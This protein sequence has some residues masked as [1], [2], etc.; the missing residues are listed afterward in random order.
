VARI[1]ARALARGQLRRVE[2]RI[3][4]DDGALLN[5]EYALVP[6]DRI[7]V[8]RIDIEGNAT[9]LDRVIRSQF[10]TVEGDPFNPRENPRERSR[11]R[12]VGYFSDAEVEARAGSSPDQVVI[13]VNVEE[14]PTGSLSFGATT[15]ATTA[16]RSSSASRSRNFLGAGSGSSG[17]AD[18]H[19]QP[20]DPSSSR[21][22]SSWAAT[23]PRARPQLPATDNA[24]RSTNEQLPLLAL[25]GVSGE[26]AGEDQRLLRA[27]IQRHP[28]RGRGAS[29]IIQA[30]ADEGGAWTNALGYVYSFDTARN[31][32]DTPTNFYFR[33]GQEFGIGDKT[34]I[35]SSALASAETRVLGEEVLLRASLEGGYLAFTEGESRVTDRYSW[36]AGLCAASRGAA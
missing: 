12:R 13:D 18:R 14:Q 10:R 23:C 3:T 27:R 15:R 1:E 28:R 11:I 25:A 8:E 24:V 32:I 19:G 22:R 31:N 2:P 35:Q 33:F 6:G 16:R 36:A 21:S 5:V 30:E 29:P 26:R 7:F 9:T 17:P 4:R 20:A 34:Y